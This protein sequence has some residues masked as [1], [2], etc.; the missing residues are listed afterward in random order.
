[1]KKPVLIPGLAFFLHT[2]ICILANF[3]TDFICKLKVL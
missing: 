2:R 1:M 3:L